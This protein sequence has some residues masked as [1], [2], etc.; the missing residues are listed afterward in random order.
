VARTS[1]PTDRRLVATWAWAAS[2]ASAI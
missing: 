2:A 1:E